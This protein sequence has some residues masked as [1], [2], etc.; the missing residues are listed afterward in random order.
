MLHSYTQ[1]MVIEILMDHPAISF[2]PMQL[3]N[4]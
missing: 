3:I 4:E 2:D 1:T